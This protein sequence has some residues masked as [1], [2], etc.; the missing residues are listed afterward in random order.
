[1]QKITATTD[2][3]A[4]CKPDD[5]EQVLSKAIIELNDAAM[6]LGIDGQRVHTS[7][8]YAVLD[9]ETLL[10][11][12]RAQQNAKLLP[13]WTN[14]R[15]WNQLS[16]DNISNATNSIR[17]HADLAFS[18]LE[19][20][21]QHVNADSLVLAVPA[22]YDKAQL[23]LLLGMCK[24][25]GLPVTSLVDMSL[26]AI[27]NQPSH[28]N[29]MYLDIGL[30]RISLT[31]LKADG[32]IRQTG[33]QTLLETGLA[34]FWDRWASL[35]AEQFIQSSR[36]DPMHE[37]ASE[38][39]L[40]NQLPAFMENNMTSNANPRTLSFELDLGH[41]KHTTS[42]SKQQLLVATASAYPAIVQGIRQLTS[43]SEPSS[44]FVSSRFSSFPDLAAS[45]ALIPNVDITYLDQDRLIQ[46]GHELWDKL[47]TMVENVPH[48]TSIAMSPIRPTASQRRAS[49]SHL[50]I[51]ATAYSLRKPRHVVSI[52]GSELHEGSEGAVGVIS[53][54]HG[55]AQIRVLGAGVKLNQVAIESGIHP[56]APGD[57]LQFS[58]GSAMII[59]ER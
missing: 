9:K 26:L 23:G 34:T 22:Y 4:I 55:D 50:L 19:D 49:A 21:K 47:G 59:A 16:T 44:L 13:R 33:H 18:H 24:E 6:H 31:T 40:F 57:T 41:V 36:F 12:T 52:D 14:N 2:S 39:Q 10:I 25:A 45:L 15:F 11:G 42:L 37:A 17:H 53:L 20:L 51:A 7:V 8:G 32:A 43:A 5:L 3:F 28:P 46:T 29:A 38:Q 35:I 1:M 48:L 58:G 54:E 27:A 30:H 56:L